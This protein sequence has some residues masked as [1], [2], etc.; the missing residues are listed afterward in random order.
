MKTKKENPE[1][2]IH[3]GYDDSLEN[4]EKGQYG[5]QEMQYEN[6]AEMDAFYHRDYG[7]PVKED[8]NLES[9]SDRIDRIVKEQLAEKA[10]R[11]NKK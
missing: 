11:L 5:T 6:Q 7:K 8:P 1:K 2:G 10:K 3:K 4:Y 9:F